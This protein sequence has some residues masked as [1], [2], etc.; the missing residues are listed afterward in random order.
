MHRFLT[1]SIPATCLLMAGSALAS[2]WLNFTNETATRVQ[3]DL[4]LVANDPHIPYYAVSIWHQA[5]LH[6]GGFNVAGVSLAGMPGIMIGRNEHVA[7]GITNNICSQRDLYQ[8]RTD[9]AHPGC[10]L[11]DGKW[12]PAQLRAE[13]IQVRGQEAVKKTIRSSRNGPIVDEVIPPPMRHTAYSVPAL[14]WTRSIYWAKVWVQWAFPS[15][16][17]A[18]STGS[19]VWRSL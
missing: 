9:P 11:F 19:S 14:S 5:R 16:S 7:F 13:T 2:G 10:F 4:T 8:E 1:A 12:E 6:G 3:S 15:C 18:K 17:P